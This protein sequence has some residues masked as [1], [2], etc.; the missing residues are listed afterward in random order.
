MR[1]MLFVATDPEAEP[2]DAGKDDIKDWVK[3]VY[4]RGIGVLGDR[5][6]EPQDAR[7]V[8]VRGDELLVTDGPFTESKEWIAG[9]DIL[10]CGSL[11]EAV[12]IASRHPMARFGRIEVREFWTL[13]LESEA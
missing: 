6:R 4:G 12:E 2:Y 3:D 5:L 10:E 7:V 9:F 8:R 13:G 1:Y 11:D